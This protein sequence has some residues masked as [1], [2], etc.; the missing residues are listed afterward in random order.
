MPPDQSSIERGRCGCFWSPLRLLVRSLAGGLLCRRLSLRRLIVLLTFGPFQRPTP[1]GRF[2]DGLPAGRAQLRFC[3]SDLAAAG[4]DAGSA[5]A[6]ILAHLAFCAAAIFDGQRRSPSVY[7]RGLRKSRPLLC[8]PHS[9]VDVARQFASLSDVSETRTFDGGND[10]FSSEF[11]WHVSWALRSVCVV[12]RDHSTSL[13]GEPG[14]QDQRTWS[15]DASKGGRAE[16]APKKEGLWTAWDIA[17]DTPW[18]DC[19][20]R[21]GRR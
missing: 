2:A 4:D 7:A 10:Y 15:R 6:L 16:C 3:F 19:F 14:N 18:L 1:F 20:D 5:S 17:G 9:A 12:C 21:Q 13:A 8:G 11:L